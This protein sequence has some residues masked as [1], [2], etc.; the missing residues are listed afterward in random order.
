PSVAPDA[1]R[2]KTDFVDAAK[3][4]AAAWDYAGATVLLKKV[5]AETAAVALLVTAQ[6]EADAANT[7]AQA[8][9]GKVASAPQAAVA[10]VTKLLK[11]LE[12]HPSAA[13][14]GPQLDTIRADIAAAEAAIKAKQPKD[15]Q[16][17]LEKAGKEAVDARMLAERNGQGDA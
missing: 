5:P 3:T 17:A 16:A 7:A 15:A 14:I 4:R 9:V 10:A 13:T 1:A 2:I 8:K 12:A 6:G 11:D